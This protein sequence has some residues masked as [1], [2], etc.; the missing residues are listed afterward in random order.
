[1][2]DEKNPAT[3]YMGYSGYGTEAPSNITCGHWGP[4]TSKVILAFGRHAVLLDPDE[5]RG[6]GEVLIYRAARAGGE[7]D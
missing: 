1:M 4:P 5:A 6:I 7:E 2:D 3:E